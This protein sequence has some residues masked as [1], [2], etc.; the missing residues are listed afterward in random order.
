MTRPESVVL[1]DVWNR[2][3]PMRRL[4]ILASSVLEGEHSWIAISRLL[5]LASVMAAQLP[6]EERIVLADQMRHEAELLDPEVDQP[7]RGRVN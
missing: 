4:S 3:S 5:A 2:V 7:F 6:I 1:L